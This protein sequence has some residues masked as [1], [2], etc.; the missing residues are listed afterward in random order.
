MKDHDLIRKMRLL[1]DEGGVRAAELRERADALEGAIKDGRAL[2]ILGM[3]A[4]ARRLW[5]DI[6]GESLV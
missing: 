2:A 5:C 1:A 3:W 4:R 6:T